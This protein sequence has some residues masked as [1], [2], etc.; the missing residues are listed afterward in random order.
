MKIQMT[1]L[2]TLT[3]LGGGFYFLQKP[4]Q[5]SLNNIQFDYPYQQKWE[6][7]PLGLEKQ[8]KIR[9][10]LSQ[11]FTFLGKGARLVSYVSED[12]QY[13]LKFFKY[14]YHHPSF[15]VHL[16][17]VFPF[18]N[19]KQQQMGKVSLETVLNGYKIA[20]DHDPKG[21]G[22]LYV[23]LNQGGNLW[24][25]VLLTDNNG[26]EHLVNLNATRFVLQIKVQALQDVLNEL[27][28]NN[29]MEL[30]KEKLY[31][32]FDL[33][34][35]HYRQGLYDL[36]VG[37]LQNNGFQGD[38]PI[39]FDVSKMTRDEQIYSRKFQKTRFAIMKEKI[40]TWLQ[41]K[42][43]HEREEIMLSLENYLETH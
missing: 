11:K 6:I 21:T 36:G 16:P 17:N 5:D 1:L 14:L 4:K 9:S 3:L 31:R 12:G 42:Y 2:I 19:Y 13:V 29:K 24:K 34:L 33:Y 23:H 40:N 38:S 30:A 18:K 15:A 39:H 43:P 20:Y 25:E 41:K 37:I 32:T 35:S 22:I 10:I 28:Q 8:E 27:L 7:E 26:K